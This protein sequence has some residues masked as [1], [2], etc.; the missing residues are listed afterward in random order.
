MPVIRFVPADG[1]VDA[2]MKF[3]HPERLRQELDSVLAQPALSFKVSGH[4]DHRRL[5]QPCFLRE[6]EPGVLAHTFVA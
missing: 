5:P 4:H 2:S 3:G 6:G 1:F